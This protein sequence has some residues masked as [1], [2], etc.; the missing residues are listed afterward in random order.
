MAGV[1]KQRLGWLTLAV[2][3]LAILVIDA[4]DAVIDRIDP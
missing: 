2:A 1:I 4:L 3:G